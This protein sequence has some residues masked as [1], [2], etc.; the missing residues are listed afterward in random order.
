[1]SKTIFKHACEVSLHGLNYQ[2]DNCVFI[3]FF[4]INF[5]CL[6]KPQLEHSNRAYQSTRSSYSRLILLIS[7]L[8]LQLQSTGFDPKVSASLLLSMAYVVDYPTCI[9]DYS[10]YQ[11][12]YRSPIV[13]Q[14]QV[15]RVCCSLFVT[16]NQ[17]QST[18]L[19]GVVDYTRYQSTYKPTVAD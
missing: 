13:D 15:K 10:M 1:M 14:V 19:S 7:R 18:T 16:Y 12:T 4:F 6:L 17:L 8:I 2:V 9:V 3:P 11:S 5:C